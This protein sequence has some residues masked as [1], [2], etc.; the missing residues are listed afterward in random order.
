MSNEETRR[1]TFAS[2]AGDF[3]ARKMSSKELELHDNVLDALANSPRVG[4]AASIT[5]QVDRD[6][7]RL[8]G[9]VNNQDAKEEA[10]NLAINVPG[11]KRVENELIVQPPTPLSDFPTRIDQP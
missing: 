7:V 6:I 8:I 11:V 9:E 1:K 10:Y 4:G 3:N 2:G 5:I